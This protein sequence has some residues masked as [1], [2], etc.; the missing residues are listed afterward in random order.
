MHSRFAI[1]V[2]ALL[3]TSGA[4]AQQVTFSR[5]VAPI[6]QE[7]CQKCHRAGEAAPMSLTT[8]AESRPW[9]KAIQQKVS[10]RIMPPWHA[11][12]SI[13]EWKNE[14]RLTDREIE[15]I[16]NWVDQGAAE[17]DPTDM[18]PPREFPQ[19]WLMGE[20]DLVF[21]IPQ[22]QILPP[23]LVDQYRYLTIP[24][25][26]DEDIWVEA[27]E[28][29]PGNREVVHH[30]N[31]FETSSLRQGSPELA[32]AV[33]ANRDENGKVRNMSGEGF[34]P[35]GE[36]LG[37]VGGFLPGAMPEIYG[38]G[39][40]VRLPKGA[41]LILQ[42]HYHKETGEEA[43]DQ[44]SV[45]VRIRKSPVQQQL[46]GGAVDNCR[47]KIPAGADN[48][49]VIAELNVPENVHITAMS[50]HM[51]LRGKSFFV[52]AEFPDGTKR[53]I[54][55]VPN[56]DFNWQTTYEPVEPIA[57]PAGTKLKTRA[58]Y[59]NSTGNPFNPDATID[60]QWGEPTTDEMMLMFFRYTVDRESLGD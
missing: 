16:V 6:L 12:P 24:M 51:H 32:A 13:G 3:V 30:V 7:N 48:H 1:S 20:P 55:S 25:N 26:L 10:Q 56:Y 47:F 57:I 2:A 41:A 39:Q 17:G 11:D 60:V 28:V 38:E 58:F 5:D 4:A 52:W 19:G 49:E 15:T 14:R 59:D 40:A 27:V 33:L 35:L 44:T 8:Y 23:D 46:L 9:A 18:P 22:E 34:G 50:P 36:G 29:R 54:L 45:G 53:D 42:M 37:R 21:T 43:R 31:V